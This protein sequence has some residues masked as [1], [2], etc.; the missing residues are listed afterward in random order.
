MN[1]NISGFNKCS[2]ALLV[3]EHLQFRYYIRLY[4][5]EDDPAIDIHLYYFKD[6]YVHPGP[7]GMSLQP[8]TFEKVVERVEELLC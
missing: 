2:R 7:V 5:F 4:N 8:F 3:F 1:F 6:G